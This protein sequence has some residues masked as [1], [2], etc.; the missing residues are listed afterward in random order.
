M[1]NGGKDREVVENCISKF[2]KRKI[3]KT[4][5]FLLGPTVVI[6]SVEPVGLFNVEEEAFNVIK[7]FGWRIENKSP[8]FLNKIC[9]ESNRKKKK[10]QF[11]HRYTHAQIVKDFAKA[12]LSLLLLSSFGSV[13]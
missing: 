5:S 13:N 1:A 3:W 9:L 2:D 10:N 11:Q 6:V 7:I 8:M 12:H 4:M